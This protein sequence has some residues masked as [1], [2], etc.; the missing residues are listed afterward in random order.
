M[1]LRVGTGS[2]CDLRLP[3]P[4]GEIG[5]YLAAS[6]HVDVIAFTGSREVGLR[7]N[8]LAARPK[9]ERFGKRFDEP[10]AVRG[11]D[12]FM[13]ELA[14]LVAQVAGLG[15]LPWVRNPGVKLPS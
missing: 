10:E 12:E 1:P 7:I 8:R 6:P 9:P 15:D 14:D 2:D 3:G 4:G 13:N 5:E 11:F